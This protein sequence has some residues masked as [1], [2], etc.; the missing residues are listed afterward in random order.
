MPLSGRKA[1]PVLLVVF[2]VLSGCLS[3]APPRA[4]SSSMSGLDS[5]R[6]SN[7]TL[8]VTERVD[9]ENVTYYPSNE[10]VRYIKAWDHANHAAVENGSAPDRVPV[11]GYVSYSEW[12]R[13]ECVAVTAKGTRAVLKQRLDTED[14]TRLKGISVT[15]HSY[16]KATGEVTVRRVT[17]LDRN[18]EVV[19]EPNVTYERVKRVTP[20]N[21]ET[22]VLLEDRDHTCTVPIGTEN[23]TGQYE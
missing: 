2:V 14:E 16:G 13:I 18:G 4:S 8:Y 10:T 20:S 11:Y 3:V 6:V 17:T 21:A 23:T 7:G 15:Y 9:S 5:V 12:A 1:L 19:F 22:T